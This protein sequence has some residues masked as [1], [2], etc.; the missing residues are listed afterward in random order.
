MRPLISKLTV[1][2]VRNNLINIEDVPWFEYSIETRVT[3]IISLVPFII[4]A[5]IL[6][7]TPTTVAFLTAFELLRKRTGGYHANSILGCTF[8]SLILEIL[9]LGTFLP[10]LTTAFLF[11]SNGVSLAIIIF[12]APFSH[13]NMNLSEEEIHSLRNS[14]RRRAILVT[15]VAFL[16]CCFDFTSISKGLTTGTAMTAFMLCLAYFIDWRKFS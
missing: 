2:C 8:I 12:L 10:Q 13:L 16:F 5:I 9:F 4:L 14:A 3:A 6:S 11:L 1:L 15:V 7:D